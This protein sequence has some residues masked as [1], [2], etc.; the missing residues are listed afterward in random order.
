MTDE[1]IET[2]LAEVNQ[3]RDSLKERARD[4]SAE[5]ESRRAAARARELVDAMPPVER[6]ALEEALK[7]AVSS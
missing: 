7:Q 4:L 6:A 1:E 5:A 2:E 3:Q